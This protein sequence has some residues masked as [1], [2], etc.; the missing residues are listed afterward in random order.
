MS[1]VKFGCSER[2]NKTLIYRNFEYIKDRR[3]VNG[4]V[5]WR[6]RSYKSLSCKARV[7]TSESRIVSE[8]QPDHNHAGN[9]ATSLA[10]KAVSEMKGKMEE[11][12]ATPSSS[13]AAVASNLD[14]HVLMA[15]P[16]RPTL[17][18]ALQRHRQKLNNTANGGMPLPP[19]PQDMNFDIPDQF[20]SMI[21]YDSGPVGDRIILIG[22][23]ELLDGL[24]R[25]EVWLADG[26]FKVVPGLFF[27]LYS[28][29]FQFG[30][31]V[32]PAALYCLLTNKTAETYGRIL[33]QLRIL[34]P[35]A[36]PRTVLV[37][38]ERAAMNSFSEAYPNC[39]VTGCYFHLCQSVQRKVGEIGLKVQYEN[40]DEVRGVIR[41][42]AA[43]A[44]V[45]R[46]DV[47]EAFELLVESMPAD[48]EHLDELVTFFEH[49]Y[50][51]GRRQRGRGETYN[52]ALFP[53]AMWN[54]QA[55]ATDGIARTTNSV[56]GWHNG[57]QA[58]FQCHH[59]TI[60]SFLTGLQRDI[61][62]QKAVF[63]QAVS[64]VQII[65]AKRYR[66]L[67]ARVQRAV[68]SYGRAE[69]L[70]YLRAMAHLSHK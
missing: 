24:A 9:I 57:I 40:N 29:H 15:L 56:E 60:W 49:T 14:D 26:T 11:L 39:T 35:A 62:K 2:G 22:C 3:N 21:L 7:I 17:N 64:G 55:G 1:V 18:R 28:I 37:D 68:A 34:V 25:A 44:F 32:N 38:F 5:S 53:I 36:A 61:Q 43:L 19:L 63:L 4:T 16:K 30:S 42:L 50:I 48:I 31:G 27:Q 66:T 8:R 51:R 45:P 47:I 46:E 6:C 59:P 67:N 33:Q 13:Q 54:Q 20:R 10:R 65:A 70:T 12:T 23:V 69:V 58:L 41:C 52:A